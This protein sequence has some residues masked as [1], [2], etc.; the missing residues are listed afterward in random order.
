MRTKL[1]GV[2]LLFSV[3]GA[4]AAQKTYVTGTLVNIES[5]HDSTTYKGT[6]IGSYYQDYTV[7]V[8]DRVYTAWCEEKLFHGC[9]INFVLGAPVKVRFEKSSMF[10]LRANGK[11]QKTNI[12]KQRIVQ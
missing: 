2:I 4:N 9:D 1:A 12:E 7:Q 8:G 11:E 5:S 3:L 10:L 6:S